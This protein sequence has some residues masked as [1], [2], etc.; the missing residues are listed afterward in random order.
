MLNTFSAAS[1]GPS[2]RSISRVTSKKLRTIALF[3]VKAVVSGLL[4]TIIFRKAGLQNILSH[5]RE[6]DPRYFI[7]SSLIYLFTLYLSSLRWGVLLRGGHPLSRLFSLYLLGSFFNN[8]LPGV[9]GGDAVKAYYLY[10][11]TKKGGESLASVF[12]DRYIG[13][14]ALLS[15]G[16]VSGLAAFRD[17][18]TIHMAWVTPLLFAGFLAGSLV[19]FGLQIGRRFGAVADF[20]D[21][22]H[23]VIRDPKV[24]GKAFA[25]SLAVQTL[26]ILEIFIIAR[27]IGQHPSFSALFVFVPVILTVTIVP[28]SISGLGVREGAF[29]VLFGMTGISAEASATISFL[30]FLSIA[31]P[32]LLGLIEYLRR[33]RG[34]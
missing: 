1:R 34:S 15:I 25:L 7:A 12:M 24:L 8:L 22:F 20:Y 4:L 27:G 6:M 29:V 9:V 21:Y 13:F 18:E 19:V 31:A 23:G 5:F 14:F 16:M 32:S 3:A 33:P 28:V 10:R 26:S 2:F 17:L 11:D 30:W